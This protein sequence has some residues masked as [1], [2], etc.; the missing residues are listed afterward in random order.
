MSALCVI[1]YFIAGTHEPAH[2]RYGPMPCERAQALVDQGFAHERG[3]YPVIQPVE[4][5]DR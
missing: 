3:L 1:V 5:N 2:I 4:G